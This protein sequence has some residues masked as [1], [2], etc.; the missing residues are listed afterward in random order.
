L[1]THCIDLHAQS[2]W[3]HSIII[4]EKSDQIRAGIPNA[5][6]PGYRHPSATLSDDPYPSI[7]VLD[8]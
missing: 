6:I 4:I 7:V 2:I 5:N 3:Q 1:V 8:I